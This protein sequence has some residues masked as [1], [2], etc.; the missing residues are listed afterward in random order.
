MKTVTLPLEFVKE[1][2]WLP[3]FNYEY[4]YEVSNFGRV[5]TIKRDVTHSRNKSLT[6][7]VKSKILSQSLNPQGYYKVRLSYDGIKK[8]KLVHHL[9]AESFLSHTKRSHYVCVDHID[10]NPKN[11]KLSNLQ[12]ISK[13][14][15]TKKSF[16]NKMNS[17]NVGEYWFH[18]TG[19]LEYVIDVLKTHGG[20]V[21]S[22]PIYR[23][24]T[25]GKFSF[26]G[27]ST[28]DRKATN[29]EVETALK[30]SV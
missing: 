7:E 27:I 24:I 30:I 14:E 18:S 4:A 21:K 9:V 23:C 15:N 11:N 19:S 13:Q 22:N 3:V 8:T 6:R 16:D 28:M 29:Q 10:E 25:E 2:K 26:H 20:T 5:R 17:I 1:E 12:I